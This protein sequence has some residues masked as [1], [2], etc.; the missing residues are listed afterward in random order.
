MVRQNFLTLFEA[1]FMPNADQCFIFFLDVI[2]VNQRMHLDENNNVQTPFL[3]STTSNNGP[4]L[5][6]LKQTSLLLL[7][8]TNNT[9]VFPFVSLKVIFQK[10]NTFFTIP[11]YSSNSASKL[12]LA[13]YT[14]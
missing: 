11:V 1:F 9:G 3:D 13:M 7:C 2:D 6:V 14:G 4:V 12:C 8:R 5:C 10:C